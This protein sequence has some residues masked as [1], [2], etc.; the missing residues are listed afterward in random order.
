[1][2]TL[3]VRQSHKGR[4]KN[5]RVSFRLLNDVNA[6]EGIEIKY[7]DADPQ[8]NILRFY[9]KLNRKA[10]FGPPFVYLIVW[11]KERLYS[12]LM[13]PHSGSTGFGQYLY[14]FNDNFNR[15]YVFD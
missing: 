15:F 8:G 9:D 4:A 1:M 13:F 2:R 3:T 12:V 6:E 5:R 10:D 11:S 7:E 14:P